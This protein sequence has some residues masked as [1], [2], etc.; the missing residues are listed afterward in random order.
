MRAG[1]SLVTAP[2]LAA[3]GRSCR[4]RCVSLDQAMSNDRTQIG[5][6]ISLGSL[7]GN[8]TGNVTSDGRLVI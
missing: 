2:R 3:L 4:S 6:A 7:A 8:I 5:G 1:R